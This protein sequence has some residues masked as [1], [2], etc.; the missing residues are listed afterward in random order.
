[1]SNKAKREYLI[2]I[3]KRYFSSTKSEKQIILDEFCKN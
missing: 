2:E 3:R 1:M